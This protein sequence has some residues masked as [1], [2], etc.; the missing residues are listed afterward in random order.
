[1]SSEA[2][3]AGVKVDLTPVINRM[4]EMANEA[5]LTRVNP[6]MVKYLT[7]MA[8]A[9]KTKPTLVAPVEAED[10]L[11]RLNFSAKGYWRDPNSHTAAAL[12]EDIARATRKQAYD[13][14]ESYKGPGYEDLRKRYGA[15]LAIEKEVADRSTVYSRKGDF[16]FFDLANIP[17]AA[18][19]AKAVATADPVSLAKVGGM[20]IV[21]GKM[22]A[23]NDPSKIVKTMFEDVERLSAIKNKLSPPV[24]TSNTPKLGPYVKSSEI[25]KQIGDYMG[26]VPAAEGGVLSY[27]PKEPGPWSPLPSGT[28][29]VRLEE[30][31]RKAA[32][33]KRITSNLSGQGLDI[34]KLS[35]D[36]EVAKLISVINDSYLSKAEKNAR[37]QKYVEL[38]RGRFNRL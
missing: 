17:A 3:Q 2:G 36:S 22:K 20:L 11:A 25:D 13:A 5:N 1:M 21:K 4:I 12:T 34:A 16:G 35:S 32:D 19:F 33:K 18:E 15:Q 37:I 31:L 6:E 29:R 23:M 26:R 24:D 7:N 14:V 38:L 30:E 27:L 9:W 28:E 8:E 10:L